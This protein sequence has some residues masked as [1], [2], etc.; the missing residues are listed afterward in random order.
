MPEPDHRRVYVAPLV[1]DID[2]AP[3]PADCVCSC[4][5]TVPP[6]AALGFAGT[7]SPALLCNLTHVVYAYL[8]TARAYNGAVLDAGVCPDAAA[9]LLHLT[10][11]LAADAR[12]LTVPE[13]IR[14]AIAT[15]LRLPAAVVCAQPAAQREFSVSVVGDVAAVLSSVHYASDAIASTAAVLRAAAG[16]RRA[17]KQATLTKAVK[18]A[19]FLLSWLASLDPALLAETREA[20]LACWEEERVKLAVGAKPP[21]GSVV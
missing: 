21:I 9:L 8:Y 5:L 13:A 6:L 3:P 12:F 17:K 1:T 4:T 20:V 14:D 2:A 11:V 19:E 15:S 16:E 18:K 10:P 7:P